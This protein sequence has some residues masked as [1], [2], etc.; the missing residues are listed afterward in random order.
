VQLSEPE[1]SYH[2]V[3]RFRRKN[4]IF[5]KWTLEVK[6]LREAFVAHQAE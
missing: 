1:K 2:L 6:A 5:L 4:E 3:S